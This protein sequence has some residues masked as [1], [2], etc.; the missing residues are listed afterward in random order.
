MRDDDVDGLAAKHASELLGEELGAERLGEVDEVLVMRVCVR[1]A[2]P[3][4]CRRRRDG[5]HESLRAGRDD[6]TE[7]VSCAALA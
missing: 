7:D 3:R 5:G 2:E 6:L 4:G 1:S